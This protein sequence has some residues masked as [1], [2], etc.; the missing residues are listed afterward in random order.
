MPHIDYF[1]LRRYGIAVLIITLALVLMLML[2][3]WLSMSGTPFLLFFGAVMVSAWY[4]GLKSGLLA[5]S[6]SALLS[7]YFFLPPA[8]ELS[9]DLSNSVRIGLFALQ[10][11]L[12]S[13]LCEAF[14]TAKR[15]VDRNLQ[16]LRVSEERFRL[17]LSSSDIVVFQQDRDL[18]YQWIHNP[19]GL[20][21]AEEMLGKS[22]DELFTASAAEQLKA[23]KLKVIE[24]GISTREE[25][26]LITCGEDRYYDLLVEPLKDTDNSIHG[27]TCAAV[28]I[29]E[30]K[31]AEL[32]K[33]RLHQELQQVVQQKDES[34]ALLNAW[35]TSSPVALAFLDSELRYVYANEALAAINGIPQTQ[36]IGS[37]FREVLPEWA[38]QI[39]PVFEQVMQTGQPL[40]NQEVSGETYPPGVYRYGLVS[41]YPVYLPNGHLLGV[42]ISSIDIT[43]LKQTEQ[44]LR[45]SEAKFRSVVES[46]MI[47]IGFW[48]RDGRITDANDALL[49]MVGYSREELL[50]GKLRWQ[51]LTPTEYLPLDKEALTQFQD[52]PFCTPYQKEYIR[53]D[54]S[55]LPILA[56]G[57]HFEGTVDRGAFFVLD[58]TERKQAEER[59]RY[60]AQV[61]SFLSTSLDYE[62]TLEQI[63]KI[64]VPQLADW[65]SIDIL[66][67][68]G[69]IRRLPITHA[70]PSKAELARK[71]QEYA[72]DYK[73]TSA[74]TRVLETGQSEL[75]SEISDSLLVAS[76]QNLEHLE[77][78]RQL[79]MK[80]VMIVPLMAQGRVLGTISFVS[81]QSNRR[82]DR[83]DLT[84]ATEITHRAALAMEN[85]RLYRDIQHA[86]V[87]YAESL[88]LLDA[89]LEAAP[90][91]VCF[92]DRELRYIRINQVFADINGL[93]IEEHLG[94][95]FGEVLPAM[96]AEFG[97]QLQRVLDTG[98][99]LLN[100]E[101]SGETREQSQRYGYWL[102]NYYP[103]NNSMGE[104]VGIGIIL[105]DVTAAKQT[106]VA[107]R[108]SEE[109]FRAMFNQAAVG[110][111]LVALDGKFIQ[112][113]PALCE[114]TGYSPEELMQITFE[115]ITHPDDLA[116]DLENARRVLAKEISGYSLE[117][118]YI[119]KDGSIVWV[120]LT[121]SAVWDTNGL[122]KYALGIIEDI[123]ERK[124][125]ETTQQFLVE[126][127]TLLAA[128]LD[129]EIALESV[130]NLAVPTLAD[131]C[132]VDVF[133]EDWSSKQIAIAIA[134]PIKLNILDEIRRRYR[135]KARAKEVL[136]QLKRGI[137]AFY[138]E[139]SDSNLVE[140][141]EDEEHLQFL[142][143]LGIRSL[144]II[145]VRSRGQLFGAISFFT[146]ESG[147]YY[148]QTDL[149]LAEDIARRAA[150][151][152]DNARLYQETQQA[153]QAAER[154]VNRTILLQRITAAL[155]EALTPQQVADVV[156]NQGIAALEATGGSVV[157][158]T[159]GDTTLKVVQAIGYSQALID[160]WA[161]FP[162][163]SPNQIAETV[164]T[165]QPIFLENLAAMI[166]R[167]PNLAEVVTLTGNNSWASIPLIAEGKV[168]GALGLSFSKEQIFNE[169]DR[170]F[171]LTVGQQCAQAIARAQLYEAE[172]TARAQA[173]TANRIKD[174]FLA[175]LSHELRTPLN[176]ILGW[177][178][179]LRTRNFDEATKIRALETIERN[180]KLQTQLIGDLLDVSR[181]LQGKVRLNLYAVDLKIAIAGALET[182]R[183]AAEAKSIQI[184]TVLSND[185]GKVLGDSDRLQQVMWNLLSNAVKFTPTEGR[186]EVRL[187]QVGLDAQIQVIDTGKGIIPE[188]LPYVF[189]YFRQA[190]AKTTRVFGGLGL[191][192]AIVRHLV[193]LHGGTVQAE[194][195]GEGQGATFTVR[196]PLLKN[197][198]LRVS[199][200]EASQTELSTD[201]TLL[202]G[203]QILLVD[204][205]ADV[206]EFFSFALEQYGAT[207]TAVESAA[208]A[209][210]ILMQS[211]PDILLSDI[212][213]PLMD[214]YMLLREVRKLPPEQN[215]QIPAIALTAYAGEIN[216]NQAMAAGFQKHLPKPVDP[217]ELAAAIDKLIR[218]SS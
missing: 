11:L 172:K 170:G 96:A 63:A 202:A 113:N 53:Q 35:L 119:R 178:K 77:L 136:Q 204:D 197:S 101:I 145:P 182:V 24:T 36:H 58:I 111:T 97:Q 81:T 139:L 142:Q 148:Q 51:D 65:C 103:V 87:H 149:A 46:N 181:I 171:M 41:Y 52:S 205:Q 162:I 66:N 116:V 73:G 98:E 42:G 14:N 50:T 21:T 137:S 161:T 9:F 90:V 56:G 179:L 39:E 30:R 117:K 141:A 70:D 191:G 144:M 163:T 193:E 45:E 135:P 158:L 16:Q 25:V 153:K 195:L 61:S 151:A 85:A 173:E 3:P 83:T 55:R 93:T 150:I 192:L 67:E 201:D 186:V 185:I 23:I 213:M 189:D 194:S 126:A 130:A 20:D 152:I 6:L 188:F 4:G 155:S 206:R 68:D 8:Y 105:A 156:V 59:L 22:D 128:S 1:L 174:E 154:S 80:S 108:E 71:L 19:Q 210:E 79:G 132:I 143:S 33:A 18:R 64:S 17:A 183:L 157:L 49:N 131:W 91:A 134:D 74:I 147:R 69:S 13:I 216:Y 123:S 160:T 109:R 212:G 167:Y 72:T 29:T 122:P 177:A 112:V 102:G 133:Q 99:P 2:D 209:L 138:S 140:M 146:A 107:L 27:I 31:Q 215:G 44:A 175:V 203:L 94:R 120:N 187:E 180:A 124:R 89:L 7:N 190:D 199:S 166:A 12:F 198:E 88:S 110:I 100:V 196:L 125:V 78:V 62:E 165:G 106:E 159:E 207:V 218:N 92:L 217:A 164:R 10:G 214:G 168:I 114:I 75:I 200:D 28:N 115:E 60:I 37:T 40:L 43:Q 26:Y 169:K 34:L 54:G 47:G 211:K 86:L 32:E 95:K 104:T 76:T 48:H 129:Y 118:R 84:L 15:Q 82:Y 38:A 5:T 176:P 208:E 184:Q 121:S 127:S 57:S